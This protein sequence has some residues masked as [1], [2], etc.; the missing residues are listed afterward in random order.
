MERWDIPVN[1][2]YRTTMTTRNVGR[3]KDAYVV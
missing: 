2:R 1:R 3:P